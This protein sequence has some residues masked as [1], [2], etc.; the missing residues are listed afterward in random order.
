MFKL[1]TVAREKREKICK[2][3]RNRHKETFSPHPDR[4]LRTQ[5][6]NWPNWQLFTKFANFHISKFWIL[7]GW[8]HLAM[9]LRQSHVSRNV[10]C[11]FI[12][13]IKPVTRHE[14]I[15]FTFGLPAL[16]V[17]VVVWTF[18]FYLH[19]RSKILANLT[20]NWKIRGLAKPD[21]KIINHHGNWVIS[22]LS[23]EIKSKSKWLSVVN[24]ETIKI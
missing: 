14:S 20:A 11:V 23:L 19:F 2:S 6:S 13:P 12:S 5:T 24:Y 10:Y 17:G 18:R 15:L 22:V 1:H 8:C 16:V 3:L 4:I 7:F 9:L 21:N